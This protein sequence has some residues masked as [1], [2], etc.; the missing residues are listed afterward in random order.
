MEVTLK[1]KDNLYAESPDDGKTKGIL[2]KKNIQTTLTINTNDIL[3]VTDVLDKKGKV[4]KSFCRLH[5]RELGPIIVN[6]SH[7]YINKIKQ[8]N[9]RPI[10]FKQ[11]GRTT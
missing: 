5:I 8:H 11:R 4:L 2:I 10:G 3:I 6:H 9:A 7:E 1:M